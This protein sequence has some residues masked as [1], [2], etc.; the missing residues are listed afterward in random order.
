MPAVLARSSDPERNALMTSGPP[1]TFT[2]SETSNGNA[3]SSPASWSCS[4]VETGLMAIFVPGGTLVGNAGVAV[5]VTGATAAVWA[6][7][8]TGAA[9]WPVGA[10]AGAV[11]LP[12]A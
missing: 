7:C 6:A 3:V 9:G 10:D 4:R 1:P 8:A 12:S 5:D 11:G 2:H